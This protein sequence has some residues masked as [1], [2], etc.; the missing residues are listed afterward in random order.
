MIAT[1][2]VVELVVGTLRTD[3][4]VSALV[5]AR[6]YP[7]LM[8]QP[9]D[10][11]AIVYQRISRTPDDLLDEGPARD[12]DWRLQIDCYAAKND[13]VQEL[14]DAVRAALDGKPLLDSD[15]ALDAR[16][17]TD[18]DIVEDLQEGGKLRV[19]NRVSM[20]FVISAAEVAA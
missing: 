16:L 13:D 1:L 10:L 9:P 2:A 19:I 6:I 20:D 11:P 5:S 7:K 12:E 18:R 3:P 4:A 14:A 17:D 8:P 15:V